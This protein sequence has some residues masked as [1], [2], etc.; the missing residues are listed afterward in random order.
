MRHDDFM[1][2][3]WTD[4]AALFQQPISM[5]QGESV[6]CWTNPRQFDPWAWLVGDTYRWIALPRGLRDNMGLGLLSLSFSPLISFAGLYSPSS[7]SCFEEF[8]RRFPNLLHNQNFVLKSALTVHSNAAAD[9]ISFNFTPST[10]RT[11]DVFIN[12]IERYDERA[13]VWLGLRW[14]IRQFLGY[15]QDDKARDFDTIFQT[16]NCWFNANLDVVVSP[17]CTCLVSTFCTPA[18]GR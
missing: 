7:M 17:E 2:C 3:L 13:L 10:A 18:D 1:R 6:C 15:A 4:R 9:L 12:Q 11:I 16:K 14:S 5:F 8:N